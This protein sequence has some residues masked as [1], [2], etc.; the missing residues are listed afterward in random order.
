MVEIVKRSDDTTGFQV[1]PRRWVVER[2]FGWLI[3]PAES[4]RHSGQARRAAPESWSPTHDAGPRNG[5]GIAT[6]LT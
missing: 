6:L 5:A 2:T 4:N 1:L 3:L